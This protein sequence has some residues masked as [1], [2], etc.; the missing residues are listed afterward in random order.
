M[1]LNQLY[2]GSQCQYDMKASGA[3]VPR[4]LNEGDFIDLSL[5]D[6]VIGRAYKGSEYFK[7]CFDEGRLFPDM[8]CSLTDIDMHEELL[9]HNYTGQCPVQTF[10]LTPAKGCNVGCAYCLVNDGIHEQTVVVY[11]NYHELIRKHLDEHRNDEHFYY[12]SPKT[13]AFCEATL[14][15]GTAH[16]ILKSFVEHYEKYPD[17]KA[18]LFIASKAGVEALDYEYEGDRILDLFIKLKGKMQFNTS[19]SLFPEG[20]IR[21]IEPYSCS[22]GNRLAAVKLCNEHG[23]MANSALVQPIMIEI[24]TEELLDGFF[25]LLKSH[26][27]VNV[28]PEFLTVSI[29]NMVLLTQMLEKYDRG[30]FRKVFCAYFRDDNLDH[31][32][33]RGRTAPPRDISHYWIKKIQAVAARHGITTSIC[34]WVREQLG[35]TEEDIPFVNENGFKCLGYQT[36]LFAAPFCNEDERE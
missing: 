30:I 10:E 19:L 7:R 26:G 18:R 20:A 29:E 31:I 1:I 4:L 21:D 12:L 11:Q 14:Q 28:K 15:T 17:S 24:L 13:E 27:I 36:R 25:A 35:V 6:E 16:K 23:I 3:F 34:N 8:A 33:Q 22:I 2:H 5:A 9:I 32:K